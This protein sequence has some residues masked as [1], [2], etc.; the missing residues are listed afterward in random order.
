LRV[1]WPDG[2]VTMPPVRALEE[3]HYTFEI[4][5]N[6]GAYRDI[7]RHRM[8]GQYPQPLTV[9]LGF[10]TP[11]ELAEAGMTARFENAMRVAAECFRALSSE[12]PE[13]A[14]YLVPLA[15]R[16][17]FLMSMDLRELHH[18]VQLRSARQGHASYRRVAQDVF[19]EVAR[20][21]PT[22]AKFIRVDLG[23]YALSRA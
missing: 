13:E 12:H 3:T 18:F 9:D 6:Y 2:A 4:T 10:E 14:Q 8:A 22:L 7:Q 19:H 23:D 11:P 15:Y 16:K 21:H 5:T 17:R 1:T 20:V